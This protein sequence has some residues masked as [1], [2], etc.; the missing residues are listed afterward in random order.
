MTHT[1]GERTTQVWIVAPVDQLDC[2]VWGLTG[3]ERLHRTLTAAGIPSGHI[4]VGSLASLSRTRT[5]ALAIFRAD[6]VF[7]ERLVHGVLATPGA[8]LLASSEETASLSPVAAVHAPPNTLTEAVSLF[9]GEEQGGTGAVRSTALGAGLSAVTPLELVPAYTSTLRKTDAPY[10]LALTSAT[11]GEV[12]ARLFAASYKGITDLVTKWVWPRPAR[13]VTRWCVSTG[14]SPNLVT[15]VSWVLVILAAVLFLGGWFGLGLVA[16]WVMTFLDTVDGKLARVTL[17][18]TKIGHVLDH[19]LDLL[20]PPFWYL[21]WAYGLPPE[22]SGLWLATVV[23]VGGYV[24]GRLLEGLFLLLFKMEIHCWHPL[25]SFFRT[26]T[27]RRNPNLILL[28]L[29]TLMGR[30]D[31]GLV[32]VAWWT[33]ICIGF[34]A[35]RLLQAFVQQGQ[36]VPIREWQGVQAEGKIT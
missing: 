8:V 5:E 7:D 27:A 21:A 25:D 26:I 35:V 20:H 2:R 10:L 14:V 9:S 34:H 17:T 36:G 32:L 29:A 28:S 13:L 6:Y 24:V 31:T 4:S 19:G 3:V 12:E 16:A 22:T 18:S 11:V 1:N 15:S 30:P 23:T 33:A